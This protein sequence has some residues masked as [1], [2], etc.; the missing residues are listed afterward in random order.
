MQK[1][2]FENLE[3][4][5]K[6]KEWMKNY[7][8]ENPHLTQIIG[9]RQKEFYNKN[10]D[11][12]EK[13]REKTKQQFENPEMIYKMLDIRGKNRQFDVFTIDG[14]FIKTFNYQ[15]DAEKYL[16]DE[17]N[18]DKRIRLDKVLS[19]KQNSAN[20]FVFKYKEIENI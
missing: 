18:I 9:N 10:P 7:Y 13:A 5:L 11:S 6:A 17:Y 16:Q 2:R 8:E 1:K 14:T 15:I 12:R 19:G 4:R 20:G 3:E